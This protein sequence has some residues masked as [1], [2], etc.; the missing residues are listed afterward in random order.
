M[1]QIKILCLS[2]LTL[3]SISFSFAQQPEE[4]KPPVLKVS[5]SNPKPKT[6]DIID[7]IFKTDV[8]AG[9]HLYSTYNK[10]DVGPMKFIINFDDSK[11]YS[12]VGELYSVGDKH[13]VDDVFNCEVGEF[14]NKAEFRQK[15]KILKNDVKVSCTYEGQWCSESTCFNFGNLTPLTSKSSI[16]ATGTEIIEDS[17]AIETP[18]VTPTID[19]IKSN[20]DTTSKSTDTGACA[21]CSYKLNGPNDNAPCVEKT[22]NGESASTEKEGFGGLF[23]LAFFSGLVGLLTPCV[24]P[25]IPMTVAFFTNDKRGKAKARLTAAFF[26]LSIIFIYTVLGTIVSFAFGADA[27]NVIS[28]HWLPNVLFFII[29][30]VFAFSFFGAFEIVLPS[31]IANKADR[32]A[33]KGGYY[34]AF[35][36][37]LTLAIVSFSCTG[38]IVGN[39]L[40]ESAG[41]Q[42]IRPIVAMFGFG[43]AF[44]L[45]FT[46]FALFPSWLN[47]LPKSG[48]WLNSVKVC[49]GFVEL[50]F[51]LKFLSTAD[52]TYHWHLLNREVYLA[53]WII[54]FGLMGLYLLGKLKFAHD[55]DFKFL[56]VPR[57]MLS[58]LVL[59]FVV[60]MIP[61]LWGAPL[62]YLAGYLP[63]MSTQEFDINR[64]IREAN[65]LSGNV[66]KKP[67]YANE[68][69]LPH[70][71]N[72]YFDYDEA[73]A[74]SKE[75]KKP[76]FI[77]FTGHGCVNC[78]KMEEMVWSDPRVL[79]ILRE[80]YVI[81]S[82]YVDDHKIKLP[83]SEHFVGRYSKR[84]ITTLGKKNAEI[85]I[86]YFNAS[87]QPLYCLLDLKE[88]LLQKP[89]GTEIN[90]KQF[91]KDEFLKYL[92]N[93]LAEFK[94]RNPKK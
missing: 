32:E 8:P 78:R 87:S 35:F 41:G 52:Q 81:V 27:G 88:N 28:T 64:S 30:I 61:G 76:L 39:V 7:V 10:C 89:V 65:G 67:S 53:L 18:A 85:E 15:I 84:K 49:I 74:C 6:G 19:T 63:P 42:F 33:D 37:A 92:E 71:L 94:K 75:L 80:D 40:V 59:S 46:I 36:M 56:K 5:F 66:T 14:F 91:D 83:E 38:P 16:T 11:A 90:N 47:S 68:L 82:L 70:G 3:C 43:L 48:G 25:M 93:G 17:K 4:P 13:I 23:W 12:L 57:L 51:A 1:N 73:V 2:L 60:Y 58:I 20:I 62:K 29:F 72:G 21:N 50:A 31:S 79:K 86:C 9:M 54:I 69:H 26:G 77:D 34:G 55:S 45:P 24:F 22:F 44:A